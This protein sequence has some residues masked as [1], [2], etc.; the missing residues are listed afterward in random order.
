MFP[1]DPAILAAVQVKPQNIADVF[2]TMQ[3]IDA[4]CV[5]EDGLKWF[6][7][8]YMTVTKAIEN[9]V[10]GGGVND[11]AWLS[12]LDV[13]FAGLYFDAVAGELGGGSC[14]ECWKAMLSVRDQVK[15][16]RIQFALAGMNAHIDHDLPIAIVSTC[17]ATNTIPQH[18]TPQYN[19]Y[20]SVNP[21]LDGLIDQAKQKLNVR[22][23]GDPLPAVSHLEDLIAT[24]NLAIFREQAWDTAQSLWGESDAEIKVRMDLTDVLVAKLSAAL[25]VPVP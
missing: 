24:W 25:L 3:T 15:I 23:P 20:T 17:Q 9:K 7:W 6:N 19:D 14:P 10:A 5:D 21:T 16:A 2:K 12:K 13:L 18:G 11:P 4:A 8:L 1:Y 22:L